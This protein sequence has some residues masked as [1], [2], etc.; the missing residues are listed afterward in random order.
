MSPQSQLSRNNNV[1]IR[2]VMLLPKKGYFGKYGG[3]FVPETVFP[4]LE[5]LERAFFK[6]TKD[7]K[8]NSELELILRTYAGRPT[9]LYFA[10][11]LTEHFKRAKVYLK[12]EDLYHTG[13]HKINNCLGQALIAKMLG[14]KRIIAETG[15]G[16]HGLATATVSALLNLKCEIY[17]GKKDMERQALNVF[18]MKLLGA[19]VIPVT[20]GTQT[21]KDAT[22]SAIRDWITNIKNTHYIIGS[23]VGPHPYPMIVSYFQSVIGKEIK[24]QMPNGK[25]PDYIVACV[26]GGSN[27]MGIFYPYIGNKKVKLI[28]IEA[29]GKGLN[30]SQHAATLNLGKPGVLHGTFS[31]LLQ[32]KNGQIQE[33][34]IISAGLD[35]PGVGPQHSYLKDKKLVTYKTIRDKEALFAFHLVSK[36]EGI[37][38]AL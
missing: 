14:K 21:L 37:I 10:K 23:T 31:Y 38:P 22:S 33:A 20:S 5:E 28:G 11:R 2:N 26:G 6:L 19:K 30:K 17:M 27:S 3:Q 35:Y 29:S 8:F 15:A 12:R 16:Q 36:L 24:K 13:A 34:H 18:K 1:S 32:D 9:P 7:K 25:D 4:A